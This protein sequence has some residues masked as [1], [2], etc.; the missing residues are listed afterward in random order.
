MPVRK[1][2]YVVYVRTAASSPEDLASLNAQ[3]KDG[4]ER[5]DFLGYSKNRGITLQDIGSGLTLDRPGLNKL[6]G[7]AAAGKLEAVFMRDPSRLSRN[8]LDLLALV[9]ELQDNGVEVYFVKGQS[10]STPDGTLP[11]FLV[12]QIARYQQTLL[13]ERTRRGQMA[14]A[15]D[16]RMLAGALSQP[17]G[18]DYDSVSKKRV[19]NEGEAVVVRRIFRRFDEGASMSKIAGM[20]NEEGVP[21]KRGGLWSAAAIRRVLTNSSYIGVYYYGKTRNVHDERSVARRVAAARGRVDRNQGLLACAG[22]GSLVLGGQ[23][24]PGRSQELI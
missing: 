12:E 10:G 22:V 21:S 20:L 15:R 4:I 17:E 11:K 14:V 1:G 3:A 5:A 7:M 19:V 23:R 2:N 18:Y 9:G 24:A 13:G 6:R 16:G 8:A